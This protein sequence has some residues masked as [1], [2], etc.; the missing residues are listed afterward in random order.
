MPWD[1]EL[2]THIKEASCLLQQQTIPRE[3][4]KHLEY[5]T[6]HPGRKGPLGGKDVVCTAQLV[7]DVIL[8]WD[9]SCR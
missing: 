7:R 1:L 6:E 5:D 3:D 2:Q 4:D 9:T 8:P